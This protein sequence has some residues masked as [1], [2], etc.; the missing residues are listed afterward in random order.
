VEGAT[1]VW[2]VDGTPGSVA[3]WSGAATLNFNDGTLASMPLV[4]ET[5]TARA[6][7]CCWSDVG[8]G[9]L[10]L[11]WMEYVD[12][13]GAPE[14]TNLQRSAAFVS[15]TGQVVEQPLP[16]GGAEAGI[17]VRRTITKPAGVPLGQLSVRFSLGSIGGG[18]S[19][20]EGWFVD[21]VELLTAE[22]CVNGVD[23]NGNGDVDCDDVL[24]ESFDGCMEMDCSNTVDDDGDGAT[25]CDDPDCTGAAGC[26]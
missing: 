10:H 16:I 1:S 23:D 21:D 7:L 12:L 15:S 17:W 14:V 19:G 5:V 8:L 13:P 11:T 25:D 18:W 22:D 26:P 24:C 20:G 6:E 4:D 2:A 9:D 3:P